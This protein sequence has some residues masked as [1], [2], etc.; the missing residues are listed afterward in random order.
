MSNSSHLT[1]RLNRLG[2]NPDAEWEDTAATFSPDI[3]LAIYP[4]VTLHPT[5]TG[6]GVG[7]GDLIAMNDSGEQIAVWINSA[8]K[9]T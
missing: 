5:A 6:Y 1:R 9:A 2:S 8:W 4:D 7:M 3:L